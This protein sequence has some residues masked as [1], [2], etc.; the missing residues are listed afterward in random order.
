MNQAR[1]TEN[2]ESVSQ[3]LERISTLVVRHLVDRQGVSPAA[4]V[5][6]SMLDDA[7]PQRVTVLAT[8]AGVSQ[9]SMSQLVQRLEQQ[10]LVTRVSDP[11]DGRAAL[12]GITDAGKAD[13][14]DRLRA[15][16]GRSADL[17]ATLSA[18]DEASLTLAMNVALPIVERMIRNALATEA[19]AGQP[20]PA[21]GARWAS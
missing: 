18:E 3:A 15:F 20:R 8:A 13:M 9:P 7:G 10:G 4:M 12:I 16:R 21:S 19:A 17:Q 11:D 5:V 14:A 1:R 2:S 6:L